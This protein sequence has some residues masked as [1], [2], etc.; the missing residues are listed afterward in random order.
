MFTT[1]SLHETPLANRPSTSAI[2]NCVISPA[3]VEAN[4]EALESLLRDQRRQ[5]RNEEFCAELEY[6]G[7]KYDEEIYM[8]PMPTRTTNGW[9][10]VERESE[11]RRPSKRRVEGGGSHEVNLPHL[12][13]AHRGRSENRKLP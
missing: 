5:V 13:I 11:G 2:L 10:L 8:E 6:S 4:Y 7:E 9:E 1:R 12:L 3:F